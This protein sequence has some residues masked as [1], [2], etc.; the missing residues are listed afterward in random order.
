MNTLQKNIKFH[1][2]RPIVYYPLLIVAAGA[3]W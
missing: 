3:H 2:L 1:N